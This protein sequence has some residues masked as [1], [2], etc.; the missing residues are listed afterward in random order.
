MSDKAAE[1][2]SLTLLCK[3]GSL[4]VHIDEA[5]SDDSHHYDWTAI[6][7]LLDDPEVKEWITI[8]GPLL[9]KKRK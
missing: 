7:L 5:L 2:P 8:M 3:L 1:K 9:P 6:H 4:A